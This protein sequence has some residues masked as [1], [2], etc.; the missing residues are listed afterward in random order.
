[1][2]LEEQLG[3]KLFERQP[4]RLTV[5]GRELFEFARP[6]FEGIEAMERRLQRKQAPVFRI[7]ASELVLRDY[8]PAVMEEL[9]AQ[10]PELRFRLRSGLQADMER[11]L[12]D[13]E[14]DLVITTLEGRPR[15]GLKALTLTQLPLV[16]LVPERSACRKAGDLWA[17][18]TLRE[19]LICLPPGE[20][21]ARA[22]QRGLRQLKIDWPTAIE[23]S[24]TGLVTQY[25]AN[26]YGIGVTVNLPLLVEVPGVRVLALPGFDEVEIAALWCHPVSEL[27]KEVREAITRRAR[28]L[29]P[30]PT[31]AQPRGQRAAGARRRATS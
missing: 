4:F 7:A 26:G 17:D 16:L 11:W 22:F 1:M 15:A 20:C 14:I 3:V 2:A 29:F 23:A 25:V 30:A 31:R 18:E 5:E 19:P 8:L 28:Q 9:K 24:S 6:F 12:A 13:G 27:H 10:H 21:I